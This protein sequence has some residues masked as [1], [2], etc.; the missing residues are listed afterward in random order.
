MMREVSNM[1]STQR[2]TPANK[3]LEKKDTRRVVESWVRREEAFLAKVRASGRT[4]VSAEF[5]SGGQWVASLPQG[6]RPGR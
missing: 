5:G 6:K 2:P 1:V 4:V 3:A